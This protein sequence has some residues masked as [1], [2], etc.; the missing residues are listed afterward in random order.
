MK[1]KKAIKIKKK[2]T[3]FFKKIKIY[4]KSIFINNISPRFRF[5]SN[6]RF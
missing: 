3:Y 1:I 5:R 2:V 6:R 4:E